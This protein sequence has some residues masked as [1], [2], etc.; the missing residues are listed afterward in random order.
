MQPLGTKI[1]VKDIVEEKIS[2]AGLHIIQKDPLKKV[3]VLAVSKDSETELKPD[4]VC[5][6]EYGGVEIP[7]GSGTWL[8]NES[9]LCLK[10]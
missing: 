5:L 6:S 10:L 7:Q 2:E 9:L 8:C 4:D 3:K 1:L